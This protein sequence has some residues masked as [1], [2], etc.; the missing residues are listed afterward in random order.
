MKDVDVKEKEYN[1]KL[2]NGTEIKVK[3]SAK[4]ENFNENDYQD[5]F[6]SFAG[7]SRDFYLNE[8]KSREAQK[9]G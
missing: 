6:S 9:A 1:E 5:V 4:I 8:L 7:Y 3:I 2:Q